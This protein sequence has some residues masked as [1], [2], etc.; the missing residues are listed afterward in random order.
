MNDYD[1]NTI[2]IELEAKIKS[3]EEL[4]DIDVLNLMLLPIMK[5]TMPRQ[6]LAINTV[7][8]AQTIPDPSKRDACIAAAF[9]F[10]SKYL[11]VADLEKER[12]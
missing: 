11:D 4:K 9:A 1:G 6:E 2:F 12:F 5:H 7:K 8:L 3:D 10:A